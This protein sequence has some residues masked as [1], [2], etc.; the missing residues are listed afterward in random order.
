[1]EEALKEFMKELPFDGKLTLNKLVDKLQKIEGVIDPIL[2][3]ASTCW[4]DVS[5]GGYGN[6]TAIYGEVLPV[7]GYFTW[8]LDNPEFQT[9]INYVV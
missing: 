5:A 6:L 3:S 7:A 1:M 2:N 8:S 9:V 4:I